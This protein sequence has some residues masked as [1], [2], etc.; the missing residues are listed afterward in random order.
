ML[1]PPLLFFFKLVI[2]CHRLLLHSSNISSFYNQ[3]KTP[4]MADGVLSNVVGDIITKLGSRALHEIGLWWGLKGELKKLEATVS[5]IRN[6]LLDAEEQQ[7]LNRQV[8]GWLERLEEVV[9]DADDLVDDFATEALRRR[10]MTGN[11]MTKEVSLFFSSSNQLVYGFKMGHKV[12]AIRERL[13]DI[14]ADRKFNLE[15]RTD[16][17]SIVWRDQTTSSLPEVVIGREGDKKAITELVLSSNGEECVSVL[18]IVGIG[19]L[20]KTTLAQII[21]NDELIKN[22]FEPRIWV[23]VSEPFDVKMTVG[24]ILESATGNRSEDLGLEAL[25]SRLENII[26]GKK[27]L[28]VLDDVWNENREKWQNLKRLLV[29]G[30]SGSKILITTRSKKVADISSTMAPHVLEGL[31]PDE[32][33]SL[34]LHVAL[35]GQEPKHANVREM[36]KEI[37]KKC[38]GVPLAIKTIAS[39]LYAKNPETEWLPFLTKELSRISQDGNDI[40]PTL[41]LSYDHL[42]SHLKH[43]FAYCAIYPKDY[44]I[45]VKTLIHLWVAQGFIES[46][47]TSDCLEDIGLEYFMKLWWRSFFQEVKRDRCGNVKNCKMHDL[48]HDLAIT[49]GG[50]RI[51]LVNSDAPNIDEKT[52][53]IAL[54]LNVAPQ[55]I[56]N[57]AKKLRSFILFEEHDYDQLFIYK[58][59]KFLH[60]FR[61]HLYKIKR[62]DNSIKMLKY[63]K[64]LEIADNQGLKALSNSITDLLNL[65]VLDVSYCVQLKELPKDI[66]KLVNLRHLYCEGCYSLTHMPSGLG[67]LPSLQTLS[68][69]VVAKGHI[70]SRD[71]GTINELNKL[72]NLRGRLAIRNLG[73]VDNEIVNVNLKEKP[74]LQSLKLS[75]EESWED[76]NVDRDEMAFQNLQPHP[77]LKELRVLNYGGR[78]F[79]SWFSSLTNLVYLCI[80][81][82]KRYQHLPPMDR[83][84]SLQYLEIWGVDD[85][86]YMEIEGQPTSFFPSLKTLELYRC[87][88]LK[89]W[90]KKKEDD[91]TALELLQFPCLSYFVCEDCPNLTSIPQF[92]SLD[93]SLSLRYA[94]PQLVHQ[95][96]TPSIS[97]SSSIIPPLSKLKILRIRDIKELESLPPD[98]LRNLTC[99]QRLTIE[100]C[101]AIKCLPQ[102]MRSLTSLR[103]LNINDCPQLKERCGNR[104]GA[105]WA[106]ISH[107]PNI[108]VDDQRIQREGRYLLDD[109]ASINEG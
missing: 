33:W 25:K 6:V 17:E 104:K 94:S 105:D 18:S 101:P 61:M 21:L 91:S 64:Y 69:F 53:H 42:P 77:N 9:Y 38:H 60:V 82:C 49:V 87:P 8:K 109:E 19:G 2:C 73:C 16:Q 28:L 100:I 59:L 85:L 39:L 32:S 71:V 37:L 62:V 4:K 81:N 40:M 68:L 93:H 14:E 27:Y 50:T 46:S 106:F 75:W 102:E 47:S 48:I 92:P 29:G 22:S 20:G 35:E 108:E 63:L 99:L 1:F 44:V 89:G 88:K 12:K 67:Q 98:G 36:G 15:V 84:P 45:D 72:N 83:I 23:C 78:R 31:S 55:K 74:L 43:C 97:S 70:T 86:E 41:K 90:Q 107:I 103:E 3:T 24:K 58:N 5:S 79:P 66:K 56:L 96:F 52:H 11:R 13:A 57:N 54:N 10:V 76:S 51:Q 34:F 30:S 95:I 65:H 26:S 80:W 7:K